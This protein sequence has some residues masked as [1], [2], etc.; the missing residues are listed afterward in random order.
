MVFQSTSN[1][2]PRHYL[3]NHLVTMVVEYSLTSSWHIFNEILDISRRKRSSYLP[4]LARQLLQAEYHTFLIGLALGDCAGQSKFAMHFLLFSVCW[5]AIDLKVS[6]TK[7]PFRDT[8]TAYDM[9]E[10]AWALK[11]IKVAYIK[12]R[13][14]SCR[15]RRR[16]VTNRCYCSFGFGHIA[17]ECRGPERS[18][19]SWRYAKEVNS[20]GTCSRKLQ[21]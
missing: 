4:N 6:I 1:A 15:V 16:K 9:L 7:R 13:R 19:N 21:C 17:A 10:R 5:S 18:R 20:A 12:I 2:L 11:R 3:I 14:I 8:N